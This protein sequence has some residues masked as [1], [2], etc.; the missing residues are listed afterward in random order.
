MAV[1]SRLYFACTRGQPMKICFLIGD[2]ARERPFHTTILLAM[3]A[4]NRGHS[5][6]L[7]S[8]EDLVYEDD[9][10]VLAH[11]RRARDSQFPSGEAFL[12][13]VRGAKAMQERI[14]LN[15]LDL[16]FLRNDP[17]E[18][19]IVPPWAQ[20]AGITFGRM[21]RDAGVLVLN[22]PEG[23][24]RAQNKMYLQHFPRQARPETIIAR[25]VDEVLGFARR[26]GAPIVVKPLQA[27]G[28][29]SVFQVDPADSKNG[30]QMV[31]AVLRDGYVLAQ[32]FIPAAAEGTIRLFLLDGKPLEC[33]GRIGAL[34]HR[35][36]RGDLRSNVHAG[37]SVEKATIGP[38]TL[39]A[40]RL[41]G[42][43]LKA[44]G[45]FF[46]GIDVAGGK[47]LEIN[48]FCPGGL[49]GAQRMEQRPFARVVID[50]AERKVAGVDEAC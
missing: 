10:I 30:K 43:K 5:V 21:L 11:A 39:E 16:F 47:V 1:A 14:V 22:D 13:E 50:A 40:G 23:L 48:P 33:E 31:E 2:F 37:G 32:E 45:L 8:V 41:I 25:R 3:E 49:F 35:P 12:D 38:E 36:L 15:E 46:V 27:S 7:T 28:G 44:D 6:W 26:I 42:P 34:L 24:S 20:T 29:R 19:G 17:T 9:G 18:D 4:A